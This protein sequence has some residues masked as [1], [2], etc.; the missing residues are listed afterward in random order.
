MTDAMD[1][2][3]AQFMRSQYREKMIEHV[4]I[5]ELWKE[6]WFRRQT[7]LEVLRSEVDGSG[8]DLLLE[9]NG[10]QRHVQLKASIQG[11]S[12]RH[13]NINA[14]LA[15]RAGGCVIWIV[16]DGNQDD[17]LTSLHYLFFG[18]GPGR[19][20]PS[21]DEYKVAKHTRANA[22]G[23]KGERPAIRRLA[24]SQFTQIDSTANLFTALFG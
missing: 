13:Q 15:A 8:F 1:E 16:F 7:V 10:T 12:T 22:K 11:G 5:A 6:A 9:C 20:L 17:G 21:L 23:V 14:S 18:G 4:V 2:A 19:N 3:A 24:R